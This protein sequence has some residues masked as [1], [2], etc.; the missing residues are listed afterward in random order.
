MLC[1]THKSICDSYVAR[2]LKHQKGAKKKNFS[3]FW[4]YSELDG[5]KKTL[6]YVCTCFKRHKV[7]ESE[8]E[9]N[10]KLTFRSK[11]ET[12]NSRFWTKYRSF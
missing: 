8:E 9:R 4:K 11:T 3:S 7:S 12:D 2:I 10:L 1:N 6:F 5:S